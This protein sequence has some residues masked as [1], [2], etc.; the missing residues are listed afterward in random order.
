M[1]APSLVRVRYNVVDLSWSEVT[2]Y[3]EQGR[4]LITSYQI[5]WDQGTGNWVK[6]T[7]DSVQLL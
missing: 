1:A 5:W 6:L 3:Q 4:D 2:G 7:S